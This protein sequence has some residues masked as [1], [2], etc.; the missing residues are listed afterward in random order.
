MIWAPNLCPFT[1]RTIYKIRGAHLSL[2][3][4][5]EV[6]PHDSDE[7]AA[8]RTAKKKKMPLCSYQS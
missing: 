3:H 4:H 8:E 1:Y 5:R 2:H 6:M 7:T